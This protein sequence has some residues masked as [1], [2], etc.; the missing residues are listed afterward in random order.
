MSC[1]AAVQLALNDI[2]PSPQSLGT[3]NA[4]ALTIT[5]AIRTV[6]PAA[7]TS[8]FAAGIKTQFLN[9]YLVWVV[10]VSVSLV[11]FIPLYYLPEKAE[12]RVKKRA[13]ENRDE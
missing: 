6:G 7:F 11:G 10:L 1:S 9:G 5:A 2:S 12:G 4:I 8:I 3:L 13:E